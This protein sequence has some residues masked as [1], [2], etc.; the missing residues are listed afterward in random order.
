MKVA[1]LNAVDENCYQEHHISDDFT[2]EEQIDLCR[3][4][5]E[6]AIFKN[7]RQNVANHRQSDIIRM[8]RC[9]EDAGNDIDAVAGC[10]HKYVRDIRTT[11][12]VM[13]GW[14]DREF[15]SYH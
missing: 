14:F 3:A 4:E 13:Q 1:Y 10:F 12:G 7:Y 6:Q 11:N 9:N 15:G 2:N 8:N 5:Q